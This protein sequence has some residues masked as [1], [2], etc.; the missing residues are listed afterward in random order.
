[1]HN[2][3]RTNEGPMLCGISWD[4]LNKQV[5][6]IMAADN[7]FASPFAENGTQWTWDSDTSNIAVTVGDWLSTQRFDEL[8]I[9]G[10]SDP[11]FINGF[12]DQ[13]MQYLGRW[14]YALTTADMQAMLDSQSGFPGQTSDER[15]HYVL[16]QAGWPNELR[17]IE[18]TTTK[19]ARVNWEE[20][21][22]ALSYLK[23]TSND[24]LGTMFVDSGGY[25]TF[26][27]RHDR[28]TAETAWTF[29][30]DAGTGIESGLTF[31]MKEDDVIN[32]ASVT[33][34]FGVNTT[35]R[36]QASV[37]EYGVKSQS[38]ELRLQDDNEAVQYAYHMVS[39]YGDARVRVDAVSFNPSAHAYGYL[40]DVAL[41][42][43]LGDRVTLSGLPSTAP[44]PSM[45]LFVE[46]VAHDVTRDGNRLKWAV[47]LDLSPADVWDG[48][49]LGD[50]VKGVLGAT[51][52][53]IY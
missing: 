29:D 10:Y 40:W 13:A 43:A 50:P 9:F 19:V 3:G 21:T 26:L 7:G 28:V 39:R 42:V 15:L 25:V 38:Y 41:R 35:I 48:W 47:T 12:A 53:L 32:V 18:P 6:G 45:D 36:N 34:A 17:R 16:D 44:A 31:S 37:D 30:H 33:N 46:S 14:D 4:H 11:A 1:M 8:Q 2:A 5:R 20:G 22:D 27:D 51:T 24:A 23:S 49:V 52:K